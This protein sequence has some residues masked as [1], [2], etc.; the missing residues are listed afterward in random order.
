MG[1]L[2]A[3]T[4][5]EEAEAMQTEG[6]VGGIPRAEMLGMAR[7][8]AD[9]LQQA[10]VTLLDLAA[11]ESGTYHLRLREVDVARLFEARVATMERA[12]AL[13]EIRVLWP[14]RG[15]PCVILGDAQKLSRALDLCIQLIGN[16]ARQGSPLELRIGHS[17]LDLLFELPPE[18]IE[19][20]DQAWAEAVGA[21]GE[22]AFAGVHRSE[23]EFLTRVEEGLGSELVLVHQI[24]RRHDGSFGCSRPQPEHV[25]LNL[26][27]PEMSSEDALR[28][29]LTSRA[30]EVST[31]LASVALALIRVPSGRKAEA[32]CRELKVHLFRSSDAA[33]A[34][35]ERGE[36][37]LVLDDCRPGD[38][39]GILKR[40]EKAL[41]FPIR[42]SSAHCPE[43]AQDPAA[44]I[45]IAQKRLL[46]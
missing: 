31:E 36:V 6:E 29:V 42:S 34:L 11:L 23:Q 21:S 18:G 4:L 28:A 46:G 45:E 19:A 7:R 39:P 15:K 26:T 25:I 9:R 24:Q 1:V 43:D 14:D 17:R 8:N 20:W 12:L 41:G 22:S 16:R 13:R 44:L 40:L 2:N 37:A 30:Y 32:F 33:Y 5:M 27:W 3:L 35:P 10:L 38:A